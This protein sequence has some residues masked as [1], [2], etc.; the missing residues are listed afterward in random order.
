MHER[1]TSV[2]YNSD[3]ALTGRSFHP[4]PTPGYLTRED[5]IAFYGT[6]GLAGVEL[7]HT[8]WDDVPSS[9]LKALTD[10]AGLPIVSYI[11]FV[12]LIAP[13]AEQRAA[14]DTAFAL[15]D[16][17]AELGAPYAMLVAATQPSDA[18]L[19]LQRGWLI[20]ALRAC[21]EHAQEVGVTVL[22]ENIDFPPLRPLMGRGVDCRELCAAVDSPAFRLIYD[23]CATVFV[24]EDPL[25]TLRAMTPYVAH[26]HLKNCRRLA[27]GESTARDLAAVSG[28]RYAG[29]GLDSGVINI[30]SIVQE[31]QRQNYDGYLLFEYQGEADPRVEL[32]HSLAYLR[33]LLQEKGD[34]THG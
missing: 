28:Q 7:M 24:D 4:K 13:R 1:I 25:E 10:Q 29:T 12:D 30:P 27:P 19:S 5:V 3:W 33:D 32:P 34:Q 8:Y 17:T 23:T 21:A 22:A 26:V 11:F 9:R 31:L 14:L 6:L 15:L 18:P 16:R 20:E 2:D